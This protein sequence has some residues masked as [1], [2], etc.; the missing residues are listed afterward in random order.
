M[1][2][3]SEE[4]FDGPINAKGIKERTRI[5]NNSDGTKSKIIQQIRVEEIE[6]KVLKRVLGRKGLTKFGWAISSEAE[7]TQVTTVCGL[8]MIE[9]PDD[10]MDKQEEG[11][12][13]K[14]LLTDFIARQEERN[15][16]REVGIETNDSSI[17]VKAS[18]V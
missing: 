2:T 4:V 1:T 3:G 9:H 15:R 6:Q 8:Q 11:G 18:V 17:Y 10:Q 7:K 5:E 12:N 13:H 16:N 14:A